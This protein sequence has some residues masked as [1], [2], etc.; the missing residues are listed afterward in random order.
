[1]V[2]VV[3]EVVLGEVERDEEARLI[4]GKP[5]CADEGYCEL[6]PRSIELVEACT[7]WPGCIQVDLL[8]SESDELL[9]DGYCLHCAQGPDRC[10]VSLDSF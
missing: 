1:V 6:W 9:R 8:A 5:W 7:A 10:D 3:A 2:E 4:R